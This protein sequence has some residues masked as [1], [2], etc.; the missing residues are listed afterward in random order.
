M[1][2]IEDAVGRQRQYDHASDDLN[3]M[4]I[5]MSS[6]AGV[7]RSSSDARFKKQKPATTRGQE[8]AWRR[9]IARLEGRERW[10]HEAVIDAPSN[11]RQAPG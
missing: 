4:L 8:M 9:R 7:V 2:E 1:D 5:A 10:R 3:R 11:R 6:P